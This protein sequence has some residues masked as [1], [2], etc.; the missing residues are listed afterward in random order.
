MALQHRHQF[1]SGA[2]YTSGLD[3][4]TN[5]R[6][7]VKHIAPVS[8]EAIISRATPRK[9]KLLEQARD[10]LFEKPFTRKDG[11]VRMFLKDDK[12]HVNKLGAPRCIQYRNKRYC[13]PLACYLHPIENHIIKQLDSSGTPIFAKGRNLIQRGEDIATKFNY[14][15]NPVVKSFDHH[16][17]D[18]HVGSKLL[19]L[20]HWFYRKCN[21]DKQFAQLLKMQLHNV[22]STKNGTTYVTPFTRMSGD[23]NTGC[24]N[25][26]INY[27]MTAALLEEAKVKYC[28]YIDG[29][30]FLVFLEKSDENCI[31][32]GDYSQ[33]GMSTKLDSVVRDIETIEFCQTRP[34]FNGVGY[35]MVRNPIRMLERIQ[36]GVGSFVDRHKVNY[37]TSVGHCCLSLGMGL[38]VEQYIGSTLTKLGGRTIV[39]PLTM[40]ANN[41]FVRPGKASLVQPSIETRL[42]Y[43]RAWG[44]TLQMQDEIEQFG[45]NLQSSFDESHIALPEYDHE[46][47][48][49]DQKEGSKVPYWSLRA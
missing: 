16:K 29:D 11:R 34:V 27:A 6:K 9:R 4:K 40:A 3:L 41:M 30:D 2:R 22:G 26:I 42:S 49:V 19:N 37:L 18:V 39:T 28:L 15:Q 8:M 14:F 1:D 13:L 7:I 21:G 23:Q 31:Q 35:T 46:S 17:F 25:S 43:E 45:V 12:Y 20:E 24:G 48:E 33:F 44:I 5:L 47:K 38:P 10:S 32:P 36:W